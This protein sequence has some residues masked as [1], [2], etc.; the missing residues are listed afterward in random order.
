VNLANAL[1]RL[2]DHDG[3]LAE[4]GQA[5]GLKKND[6]EADYD[7]GKALAAHND[8]EGA[9]NAYREAVRL[10]PDFALAWLNIAALL[11]RKGDLDESARHCEE[12][13]RLRPA[14]ARAH[15]DLALARLGQGDLDNALAEYRKAAQLQPEIQLPGNNSG[16]MLAAA[17]TVDEA[18]MRPVSGAAPTVEDAP[19]HLPPELSPSQTAG[20]QAQ[21]VQASQ[22]GGLDGTSS[23]APSEFKN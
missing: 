2:G 22:P 13:L 9:L 16:S 11:G 5:A 18:V 10:R 12:A 21:R 19:L 20:D 14:D 15:Y 7:L 8:V 23:S 4:Y 6:P 3:A 17:E 1:E